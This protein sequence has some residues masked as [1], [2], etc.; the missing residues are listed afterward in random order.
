MATPEQSRPAQTGPT[1]PEARGRV[2]RGGDASLDHLSPVPEANQPGHHPPEE[3]DQPPLDDFAARFG[4]VPGPDD[5]A[6]DP[7]VPDSLDT[8]ASPAAV[9][10]APAGR[11]LPAP[12]RQC[13]SV[14]VRRG[15]LPVLGGVRAVTVVLE[16]AARESIR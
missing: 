11:S 7:A 16:K 10:Q 6:P 8:T 12:W 4:I 15:V 5:G 13:W 3:Q 1:E 2:D 9:E 14:T